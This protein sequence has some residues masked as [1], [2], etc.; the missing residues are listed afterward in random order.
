[1]NVR[2]KLFYSYLCLAVT[3]VGAH[4][5]TELSAVEVRARAENLEGVA[6]A[7]SEGVV[8]S[9]RLAAMPSLL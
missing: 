6:A 5:S 2:R 3:G 1:M 4:E 8:S 9:Q 7:G